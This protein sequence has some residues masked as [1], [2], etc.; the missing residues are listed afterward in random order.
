[1]KKILI[2][3]LILVLAGIIVLYKYPSPPKKEVEFGVSFS[4]AQAEQFGLDWQE[5]Y[6][7]ILDDLGVKKLRLMAYWD[8][9]EPEQGVYNFSDLDWQIKQATKRKAEIILVIGYRLPRWPECYIPSWA[10]H[11]PEAVLSM[12][13]TVVKRYQNESAIKYWQVENEPFLW[14]FGECPKADAKLFD[15]EILLVRSL[16][17][18]PIL[19]T[20]SG[21]YSLWLRMS[22][23]ADIFGTT[24]YRKS[25]L[26]YFGYIRSP[27]PANIYRFRANL[28]KAFFD[29]Q[30]VIIVELQAEPWPPEYK[31]IID[32]SLEEQ[33]QA[34]N[35]D[36]FQD[37]IEYA[38]RAGFDKI[39][40]WGVE[41][42]FWLKQQ[43]D[44]RIWNE[45]RNLMIND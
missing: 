40:L 24:M 1:M 7:A 12:L 9:I 44:D 37:S 39:Y 41:W 20:D 28:I 33:E 45:A 18:R 17:S 27:L 35:L 42:W 13:E 6:L 43:G 10:E 2:F 30:D 15:Q 19:L 23:R 34:M 26:R 3:F 11:K 32:L 36:D 8:K 29:L 5:T 25:W 31:D 21:E 14:W 38:Q 22:K 4:P 16:D